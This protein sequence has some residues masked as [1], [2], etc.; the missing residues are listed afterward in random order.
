MLA[1]EQ[2]DSLAPADKSINQPTENQQTLL[3]DRNFYRQQYQEAINEVKQL[4]SLLGRFK[5]ATEN[6]NK[7]QIEHENTIKLLVVCSLRIL[8]TIHFL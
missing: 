1:F 5:T 6:Q 4:K 7:L 3:L 2:S 8:F